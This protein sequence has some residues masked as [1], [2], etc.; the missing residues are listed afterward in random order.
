MCR[1]VS[2][3]QFGSNLER[4]ADH[5]TNIAEDALYAAAATEHIRHQHQSASV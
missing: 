3:I 4:M 5:A 2:A 1:V